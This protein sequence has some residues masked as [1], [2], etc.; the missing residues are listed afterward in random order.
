MDVTKLKGV[1]LTG[2]RCIV[3]SYRHGKHCH[4]REE[5]YYGEGWTVVFNSPDKYLGGQTYGSFSQAIVAN[6]GYAL[7]H[8]ETAGKNDTK[9]CFVIDMKTKGIQSFR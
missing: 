7:K 8:P 2:N 1:N 6:T 4:N 3:N 9:Y 5:Q